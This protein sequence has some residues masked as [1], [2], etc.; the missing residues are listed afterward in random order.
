MLD[1]PKL[2]ALL[3]FASETEEV[4]NWGYCLSFQKICAG[5]LKISLQDPPGFRANQFFFQISIS[6]STMR[7]AA[8]YLRPLIELAI[9]DSNAQ[10]KPNCTQVARKL[11]NMGLDYI[12][13]ALY[14]RCFTGP[15]SSQVMYNVVYSCARTGGR[16][17][18]TLSSQLLC[19]THLQASPP[20]SLSSCSLGT[21]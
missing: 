18:P 15:A 13:D 5:S 21:P 6:L 17:E 20:L 10:H 11:N 8:I 19:W 16:Y 9:A 7:K 2:G 1:I 4:V 14:R 3:D 12:Q